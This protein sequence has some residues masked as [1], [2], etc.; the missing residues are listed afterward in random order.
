M[1]GGFTGF[2]GGLATSSVT[3]AIEDTQTQ[4]QY[5]STSI[6]GSANAF[7]NQSFAGFGSRAPSFSATKVYPNTV[8]ILDDDFSVSAPA[9]RWKKES[10]AGS[11]FC[12]TS[13]SKDEGSEP[14]RKHGFSIQ[15][16]EDSSHL[17]LFS[18]LKSNTNSEGRR[19]SKAIS[20]LPLGRRKLRES[21]MRIS[22]PSGP[23]EVAKLDNF[24]KDFYCAIKQAS[25]STKETHDYLQSHD[26]TFCG[27]YEPTIFFDFSELDPHFANAMYDLQFT[28]KAG[29]CCLSIILKEY[30]K[31]PKPTCVQAAS[32]PILIQGRDCIGIAETGSGK[33]L[34]FSIPALLHA[35]AQPPTSEAVPSPIV[36]VF[37]PARELALQIYM[38]IENLL[39]HFNSML[40]KCYGDEIAYDGTKKT[41]LRPLYAAVSYGG[42]GWKDHYRKM[43]AEPLDILVTTPGIFSYFYNRNLINLS[44]VTYA[45]LDECD[46]MLSSGFKNEL[47][48]LLTNS[49]S[50]RQTLLWSATWPSEVHEVAQS[51]LNEN[52]VFLGIGNYRASVNKRVIQHIVVAKSIRQKNIY[53]IDLL[54]CI[55]D[56]TFDESMEKLQGN[57]VFTSVATSI[58]DEYRTWCS[59]LNQQLKS[60]SPATSE[61]SASVRII[62]FVN[63]KVSADE[64]HGELSKLYGRKSCIIH[65]D[66]PQI[67][68]ETALEKFKNDEGSILVATD[69]VARGVHIEGVTHV[70]N[71]DI[72]KEHVSYVHRCGR[73]GRAGKFGHAISIFLPYT[74]KQMI[75][76]LAGY[77]KENNESAALPPEFLDYGA[78]NNDIDRSSH[79]GS[80]MTKRDSKGQSRQS[81][82]ND[83]SDLFDG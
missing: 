47:D 1:F 18:K 19:L 24:R 56:G 42:K 69:A 11:S 77:F 80:Q 76:A 51:Y 6:T 74:D 54:K 44:R 8:S 62:V 9:Q 26:M 67:D 73:T 49:A 78:N 41:P 81:F 64:I 14:P 28:K 16:D 48:I 61:A 66:I 36:V 79:R 3:V 68:R 30:Y 22:W 82:T 34:A 27:D 20:P 40:Y 25:V 12:N 57:G 63:K 59:S 37:A 23:I 21:R 45:V 60:Q 17:S 35:A 13:V 2:G 39:E 53:L 5:P 46:A 31:F 32:W 29:D 70:I 83:N 65:G 75:N 43:I 7:G 10:P 58:E 52:T 15:S 38:E 55:M 72:P 50:N 33:T 71:Y 4:K